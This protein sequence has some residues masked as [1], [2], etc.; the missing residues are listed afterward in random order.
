[1]LPVV[2][3]DHPARRARE[4]RAGARALVDRCHLA[5]DLPGMDRTDRLVARE[6]ADLALEEQVH[7][8][9]HQQ[10][11]DAALVLG[12]DLPS[13]G[14]DLLLAGEPEE[15]HCDRNVVVVARN[16]AAGHLI[17]SS[18]SGTWPGPPCA[19]RLGRKGSIMPP[20]YPRV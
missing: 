12:E 2:E 4:R 17:F 18:G 7:A 11:R 14:E 8:V 6:D 10:E 16:A 9:R 3:G 15:L 20:T 13:L 1:E 19:R 5:E